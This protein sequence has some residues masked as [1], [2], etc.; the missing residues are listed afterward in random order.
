M[1]EI[2]CPRVAIGAFQ[3]VLE[4]SSEPGTMNLVFPCREDIKIMHV[5]MQMM[6]MKICE[7]V[8]FNFA[9]NNFT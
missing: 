5:K 2:L 3:F 4:Y 6:V 9:R 1:T 7:L 8:H